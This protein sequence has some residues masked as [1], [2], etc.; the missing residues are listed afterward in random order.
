MTASGRRLACSIAA[1]LGSTALMLGACTG[2]IGPNRNGAPAG[3]DPSS[4]PSDAPDGPDDDPN[5][6]VHD[7]L[8]QCDSST[9]GSTP[10]RLV[11][12]TAPQFSERWRWG[13]RTPPYGP[14]GLYRF[15]TDARDGLMDDA[16]TDQLL[17]QALALAR[18]G[19]KKRLGWGSCMA[20]SKLESSSGVPTRACLEQ[21]AVEYLSRAWHR[22]ITQDEIDGHADFTEWAMA[23]YGAEPGIILAAA[24]PYAAA[25]FLFRFEVADDFGDAQRARMHSWQIAQALAGAITDTPLLYRSGSTLDTQLRPALDALRSAA[26]AGEL[27]S[28]EQVEKHARALLDVPPASGDTGGPVLPTGVRR[29]FA[30]F[31]GYPEAPHVFKSGGMP[32]GIA[33]SEGKYYRTKFFEPS[34]D[35]TLALVYLEERDFLRRVLTTDT[36]FMLGA[37]GKP[38]GSW[39]FNLETDAVGPMTMP[40]GQRSGL[41]TH[42]GWLAAHSGNQHTDPH[43]VHRGKWV[44]ENLLCGSLPDLPIG[45]EAQLPELPDKS[46]RHRLESITNPDVDPGN[47]YCWNCHKLMDPLGLPFEIYDHRGRFRSEEMVGDGSYVPVVASSTLVET[48]DPALDGATVADAKALM[49]LLSEST[50]VEECFVRYTFRF[51]AGRQETYADACTLVSM[52]DTY[53]KS[54]GSFREMLVALL[55]DDAFLY[56]HR[57]DDEGDL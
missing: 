40:N 2:D 21:F 19:N 31:L 47:A 30:E 17:G 53:R 52:R 7:K 1:I 23:K 6:L 57:L 41:L 46:V 24:R 10:E 51:Y 42:P 22:S 33:S 39:P 12:L 13:N 36:F 38:E 48:G 28:A 9:L 11:R 4:N 55:T 50:R 56:R 34:A 8:F 45:V 27:V 29:F 43:P 18:D 37:E 16:T 5:L 44:R 49:Q 35:A 15:T 54:S 14:S 20:H 3:S 26:E 25:S 32:A